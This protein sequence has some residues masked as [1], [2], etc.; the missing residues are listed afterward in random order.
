MDTSLLRK[1]HSVEDEAQLQKES[2]SDDGILS[3][4]MN[5]TE[6]VRELKL[7]EL[8]LVHQMKKKP[9]K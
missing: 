7:K 9:E 5:S 1:S 8:P 2:D 6:K 3:K 4:I